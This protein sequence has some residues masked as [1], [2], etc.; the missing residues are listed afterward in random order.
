[1]TL[2]DPLPANVAVVAW[3]ANTRYTIG[4]TIQ[5]VTPNGYCYTC[6]AGGTS[7]AAEPSWPGSVGNKITDGSVVWTTNKMSGN[8]MTWLLDKL[9]VGA[10]GQVSFQATVATTASMGSTINNTAQLACTEWPNP[11]SSNNVVL[12]VVAP[13]VSLTTSPASPQLLNTP[14]TLSATATG[15]PNVQYQFWVYNQATTTWSQLQGYSASAT[16][17]WTPST[18]GKYLLSATA[19][20]TATGTVVNTT[21]WYTITT[22]PLTA[23]AVAL[24]PTSPQ[25]TNTSITLTATAT[26]GTNVQ[27]QFWLYNPDASPAWSQLQAYSTSA[28]CSW[29]PTMAGNYLLSVT[30]LDG[31]TGTIVNAMVW[32]GIANGSTLSAVSVA[33]TVGTTPVTS[34]QTINTPITLTA[35]ATGGTGVQ[36]QFWLYNPDASPTWSQLQTYSTQATYTWLPTAAG[37]YVLSITARDSVTGTIVN[38]MV[39]YTITNGI[40]LSA[41]SVAMFPISPQPIGT[42]ITLQA[43][44]TGGVNVQYQ[45]WVYNQAATPAWNQLQGYESTATCMWHPLTTGNYLISVTA[46]D[47]ERRAREYAGLVYDRHRPADRRLRR[48][49]A[50]LSANSKYAHYPHRDAD[51]GDERAIPN[52]GATT[53]PTRRRGVNCNRIR[54]MPLTY[55]PR[56]RPGHTCSRSPRKMPPARR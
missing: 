3:Q 34:P 28:V 10:A 26:G 5:P 29:L 42:N 9:N 11:V 50:H 47:D 1:M 23:V 55:G 56:Q 40:P 24:S 21:A 33:T 32:Y 39:K 13:T 7:G 27:Y 15:G 46:K 44:A 14:I 49:L 36:Y 30:A 52:S 51:R 4:N 17:V 22:V 12:N 41:V 45:F 48:R 43:S 25:V 53:P 38:T 6:I 35:T 16:C 54:P 2:T 31:A 19:Q 18:A 8:T 20:G 37:D